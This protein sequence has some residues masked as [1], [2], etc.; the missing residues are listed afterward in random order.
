MG[1][2]NSAGE[3]GLEDFPQQLELFVCNHGDGKKKA[4]PWITIQFPLPS[5]WLASFILS[6]QGLAEIFLHTIA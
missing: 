2:G 6:S 1:V 4:L 3:L 5:C